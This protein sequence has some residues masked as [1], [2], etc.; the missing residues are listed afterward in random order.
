MLPEELLLNISKGDNAA[1]RQFYEL[2]KARVY[3]TCL[4]HVQNA[5]EAEELTQD[6]FIE[7]HN[8][9][10][11]FKGNS[12][13]S[14]WVYRIAVNKCIDL[15]RYKG[16]QK[17][18]AFI[19]SI[20]N[21]DTGELKY[22]RVEFEHPGVKIENKEKAARLFAAIRQLPENQQSAF[23]L[24]YIEGLPQKDIADVLAITEKAAESLL[25]RAKGNLRK[26]LGDLYDEN[27]GLKQ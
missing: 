26:S 14:T 18:F 3:N 1:F 7:V 21:K 20:F 16:R 8:K 10:G 17:R 13:V 2:F 19:T 12:A 6:V 5:P 25:Q 15:L 9:A 23:I 24:K 4:L 27:E 22:D 11:D